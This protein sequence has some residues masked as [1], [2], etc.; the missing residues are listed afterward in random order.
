MQDSLRLSRRAVLRRL[1]AF[2]ASLFAV[3][4]FLRSAAHG[5]IAPASMLTARTLGVAQ[6]GDAEHLRAIMQACVASESSFHGKCGEWPLAWAEK[7][8]SSRPDTPILLKGGTPVA[9]HEVPPIRPAPPS[10]A[11]D[12]S[13]EERSKRALQER[14]R[15]TFRVT[16]AGVRD[17]LLT[18]E[19]SVAVFREIIYV[20]YKRALALGYE[21]AECFAPWEK[22]PRLSRK[23]TDYPGLELV[24]KVAKAQGDGPD[25][26]WFRWRLV[27]AIQA[28][29]A[30]GAADRGL[31]EV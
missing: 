13:A 24:E 28:L 22:H 14:S 15:T 5:A 12:A 3:P 21:H 31:G 20:A 30:E 1:A 16:A 26:Y 25:V 18:P 27:D 23:F 29:E 4:R 17:D 7:F 10:L 19:E 6:S 11:Q 2:T 9:F 8:I